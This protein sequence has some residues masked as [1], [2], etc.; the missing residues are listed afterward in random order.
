MDMDSPSWMAA[1]NDAGATRNAALACLHEMLLR[2]AIREA[3]RRGPMFRIGG[4]ELNDVAYQAADDAMIALLGKL[5]SFRGESRFSTWA[6][7]FVVLEVANKLGRHFWLSP[8]VYLDAE[9]W[10]RLPARFGS[11]PLAQ[12]QQHE[13][14][15][16]VNKAIEEALTDHQ[17][18]FFIAVVVNGVPMDAMVSQSGLK[19]GTIYKAVFDARRKIRAYLTTH[20]YLDGELRAV[21]SY[22]SA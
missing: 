11:D 21:P 4:P 9:E 18:K 5:D 20:G 1:L 7:R 10:E 12:T 22:R 19:R 16:A 13:L 14:I 15:D 2:V 17:R 6:Y 8:S 3:Y